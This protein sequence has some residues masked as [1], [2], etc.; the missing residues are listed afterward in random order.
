MSKTWRE[1]AAKPHRYIAARHVLIFG[2]TR[3]FAAQRPY[4]YAEQ[5]LA[6]FLYW[7]VEVNKSSD[8]TK[9]WALLQ[10][11]DLRIVVFGDGNA[12]SCR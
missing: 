3:N 10:G 9:K 2:E 1:F 4:T 8:R 11:H 12:A 7:V 6:R 5:R